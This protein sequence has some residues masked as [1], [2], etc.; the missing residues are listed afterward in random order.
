MKWKEN[1]E[2][3]VLLQKYRVVLDCVSK[4]IPQLQE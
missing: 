4:L 3:D 2:E 1:D